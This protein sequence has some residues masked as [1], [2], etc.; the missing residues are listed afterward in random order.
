MLDHSF[1]ARGS[2]VAQLLWVSGRQH[3]VVAAC[4][5]ANAHPHGQKQKRKTRRKRL[6]SCNPCG[7]AFNAP[8]PVYPIL[9]QVP[10][11]SVMPSYQPSS[12]VGFWG[13]FQIQMI[14]RGHSETL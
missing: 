11:P 8:F 1:T 12:N 14:A 6:G 3:M 13:T 10:S 9:N 2:V 4:G 7:H 5:R